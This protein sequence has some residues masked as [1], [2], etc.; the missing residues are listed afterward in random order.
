[1]FTAIKD[2]K[3]SFFHSTINKCTKQSKNILTTYLLIFLVLQ[4]QVLYCFQR[5]STNGFFF[6]FW[7]KDYLYILVMCYQKINTTGKTPFAGS[8]SVIIS[9]YKHGY[10]KTK[11]TSDEANKIIIQHYAVP[12]SGIALIFPILSD[13]NKKVIGIYVF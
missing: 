6:N 4:Y 11:S 5:A 8:A 13:P 3:F 9:R 12:I 2:D 7:E 10:I 1:M